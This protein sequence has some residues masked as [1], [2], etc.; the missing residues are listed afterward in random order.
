MMLIIYVASAVCW[1]GVIAH[2]CQ[3]CVSIACTGL[4][5]ITLWA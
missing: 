4:P 2:C 3:Y 1:S 5:I